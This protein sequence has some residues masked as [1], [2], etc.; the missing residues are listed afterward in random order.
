MLDASAISAEINRID[1]LYGAGQRAEA[2][3]ACRR[4]LEAAPKSGVAWFR[5]GLL[6]L[7]RNEDAEAESALR[8]ALLHEPRAAI[9][10]AQLA[11][12]LQRQGL[13]AEGEEMA[14]QAVT[15]QPTAGH[16]TI[17]GKVLF[18][19]YKLDASAE[20]YREALALE[21]RDPMVW[22]DLGACEQARVRFAEAEE[23]YRN[24]VSF[25]AGPAAISNYA[26]LLC[27]GGKR[28]QASEFLQ[29]I[30]VRN[31]F[32][33]EGWMTL[34]TLYEGMSEWG[35]AAAAYRRA[36]E[37]FPD[38]DQAGYKLARMLHSDHHPSE[39]EEVLRAHLNR[40]PQQAEAWALLGELLM[41]Q[42]RPT[43]GVQIVERAVK[44]S[45]DPH[46][47]SRLLLELQYE[48]DAEPKRLLLAHRR[49]NE[50]YAKNLAPACPPPPRPGNGRP[51]RIGIVSRDL[52]QHP[53]A[54]LVLPGLEHLPRSA[55]ELVFYFD[56]TAGDDFTARFRDAATLW[57]T[58]CGLSDEQAAALV[59]RDNIDI[60]IDLM[61][62][63]GGR[64]LLFARKPAPLQVTWFG[65]VGTT[66]LT[67]IDYLLADRFHVREGE[68][69]WYSERILRMPGDYACYG[70]P[71]TVPNV[72][73]LPARTLGQ[74]T[75]GC[76]NNTPKFSVA[77]REAWA[78]ILRRV[79]TA[80]LLLKFNGLDDRRLQSDLHRWFSDRGVE[81]A[82]IQFE[83]GSP[84]FEF[85]AAYNRVDLAL[86]TQPY[87]GGLTTC[88]A[89]WMGVP[90]ITFPGNT[91][92]G[93][94]TTSHLMN[95]GYPQ[96]VA[97]DLPG[98]VE[99]AVQWAN[100]LDE[101]AE[102]R[103]GMREQVRKSPLCD[104][105]RFAKDFLNVMEQAWRSHA[106]A[107]Q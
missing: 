27:L 41:R 76:F 52:G 33:P 90:V 49:W 24:S 105:P 44:M 36:L 7:A 53:A 20:A 25:G 3:V 65:Y 95:A 50:A 72:A 30:V 78:D 69:Q 23:A 100:R 35:L 39:A 93:R 55:C 16:W 58:I 46:R 75:F 62:H 19:Q 8:E 29:P 9:I 96:F 40:F 104:A 86:D 107:S 71:R 106:T 34:G 67:A 38:H 13:A 84:H 82:R 37:F 17:L 18:D 94:H 88:E 80:R 14:R 79:P 5:L 97:K 45:P 54:F 26:Y 63:G 89:L 60:L 81:A 56:R 87:S 70:P 6:L 4:L 48:D 101:L 28:E 2:E 59:R 66:G 91:F 12:A 74:V 77:I 103:A 15:L 32:A 11:V 61:G 83:G 21:P 85:L 102:I 42:C 57:R 1:Q 22:N 99:L 92:A 64:M 68:E 31:P 47:H 73:P 43:E 98:Y 10:W 51:L